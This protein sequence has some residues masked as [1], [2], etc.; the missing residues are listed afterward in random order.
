MI[1]RDCRH[2]I[3]GVC[4]IYIPVVMLLQKLHDARQLKLKQGP[5]Q[6]Q[7]ARAGVGP[8]LKAVT[9]LWNVLL[10]AYCFAGFCAL[11]RP[12]SLFACCILLGLHC[13]VLPLSFCV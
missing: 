10:C 3:W 8:V 7:G 13:R 1:S 12:S 6:K 11:V 5:Q 9:C 4:L 2:L